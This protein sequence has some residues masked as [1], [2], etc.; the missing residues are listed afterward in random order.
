[1]SASA[2]KKFCMSVCDIPVARAEP[3]DGPVRV[4]L[5]F[6]VIAPEEYAAACGVTPL[7]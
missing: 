4:G 6:E 3:P 2:N 5:P 7:Q 1:M